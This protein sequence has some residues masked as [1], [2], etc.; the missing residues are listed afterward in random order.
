VNLSEFLTVGSII[1]T[2]SSVDKASAISE[3]V[4]FLHADGRIADAPALEKAII[5]REKLGSTGIG[6]SIAI[7]HAKLENLKDL[8]A[9][10]G[11]SDEGVE[12]DSLDGKKVNFFFLLVG[13]N[14]DPGRHLKL[15]ARISRLVKQNGFCDRLKTA[16]SPEEIMNVVVEGEEAL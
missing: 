16:T 5:E 1:P 10:I 13:P 6:L 4:Q 15:L 2:M 12:F 11:R 3:M 7:P 8:V 9:L 14:N